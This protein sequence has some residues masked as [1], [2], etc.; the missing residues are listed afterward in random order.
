MAHGPVRRAQLI[1]YY[2]VGSISVLPYGVSVITAGL[3]HWYRDSD[4]S[5]GGLDLDEFQVEEWRLKEDLGVSH[6]RLAPDFRLRIGRSEEANRGLTIPALRFPTWHVCPGCRR[7]KTLPLSYYGAN[8]RCQPCRARR[9][10]TP[11]MN[12]VRYVAICPEGHIQDFPFREWTH[13][14]LDPS[15]QRDMR[16]ISTGG[17]SLSAQLVRCRCGE[18][19]YL[20]RIAEATPQGEWSFLSSHLVQPEGAAGVIDRVPQ[21]QCEGVMPW[22]GT[23]EGSG[24][25]NLLRGGFRESSN[26]YFP[27]TKSAIYIPR[28]S[29]G[30]I[31]EKLLELLENPPLSTVLST[32]RGVGVKVTAATLRDLR[33]SELLEPFG[34]GEISRAL[35]IVEASTGLPF[36]KDAWPTGNED[37]F[38]GQEIQILRKEMNTSELKTSVPSISLY[39]P[40][41][42]KSFSQVTLVDQLRE[43]RVFW[44]F[45]RIFPERGTLGDRKSMLWRKPPRRGHEW[46][47]AYVV[48]G[49]GFLLELELSRLA[50]WEKRPAVRSRTVTMLDHY[51]AVQADRGLR[52]RSLS[53][54]MVLVHT[55]AHLLINRLT[56]ECGYSSAGLRERLYVTGAPNSMA[57][58]LIY[59]AAGDSEG[60]MGGLVRMGKPG[61][62]ER[63]IAV[64]LERARWCSSD[65]V[66]MELGESGQGPDSCNLAA[67]HNCALLP[68]TSCEEF[69]RFL[70]R[71]LV[72]GT[73]DQPD[74]AF[75]EGSRATPKLKLNHCLLG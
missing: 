24:C 20:R 70:D 31:S 73:F 5:E 75:F 29:R 65:P 51:R 13:R 12:Q 8:P 38:R 53:P 57:A 43:T 6:F 56:Y 1:S 28:D 17:A 9:G 47:P 32:L 60:T 68:E 63:V 23:G 33:H 44:G 21:Y 16:L 15:C 42:R 14:S 2:G 26:L 18:E 25:G 45:N 64:A 27:L 22:H 48:R 50:E 66:C 69:N 11:I 52:E 39:G 72:I 61:N 46:L 19:R 10:R 55:L 35:E 67:C 40:D 62:L 3:D 30:D 4:R 74:L 36:D 58:L 71:G 41:V 49:E 37:E 34:D 59:T 7:L 54:R